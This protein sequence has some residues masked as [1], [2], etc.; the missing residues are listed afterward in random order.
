MTRGG[1]DNATL[2]IVQYL[3]MS[4]FRNFDI[5]YGAVISV[6]IFIVVLIVTLIQF[7]FA[8]RWVHEG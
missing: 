8:K 4:A 1:P 6:A 7:K 2:S 5:G 3:H